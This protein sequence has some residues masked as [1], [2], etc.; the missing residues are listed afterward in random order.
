[1]QKVCD[2]LVE[3]LGYKNAWI[4][5][6]DQSG[7]YRHAAEAGL[8]KHFAPMKKMLETE[9]LPECAKAMLAKRSLITIKNP[10]K[11]CKN[12]PLST[13]YAKNGALISPIIHDQ[14]VYGVIATS[15]PQSLLT[16][17]SGKELFHEVSENIAFALHDIESN[18]KS[19]Q[20]EQNLKESEA[21]FRE[22]FNATSEAI[23][24]HD[25]N[26]FVIQAKFVS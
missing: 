4:A 21:K 26:S 7:N 14:R 18:E 6:F 11:E 3:S 22:I 9:D 24:I 23:F 12:C 17:A 2:L 10:R 20:T 15:I 5:L 19:R 1:M 8:D 25:D 13:S 16:D